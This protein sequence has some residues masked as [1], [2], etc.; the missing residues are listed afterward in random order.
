MQHPKLT[1]DNIS[2]Y[3]DSRKETKSAFEIFHVDYTDEEKDVIKNF[4]LTLPDGKTYTSYGHCGNN[5][6][7]IKTFF[8]SFGNNSD[9]DIDIVIKIINRLIHHVLL[10]YKKNYYWISIRI[11]NSNHDWDIPR[12]HRDGLYIPNGHL[13]SKFVTVVKG[14]GTFLKEDTKESKDIFDSVRKE[15]DEDKSIENYQEKEKKWRPKFD[16][17]LKDIKTLQL[18]NDDG[19]IFFVGD[20]DGAIHSEPKMDKSRMFISIVPGTKKDIDTL[21]EKKSGQCVSHQN[22]GY[23]NKL[24]KYRNKI[25]LKIEKLII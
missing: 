23:Y 14:P 5:I 7:N 18:E 22:G 20:H 16:E 13:S 10:G 24:N 4:D 1:P 25:S 2:N 11:A 15:F 3:L 8:K 9:K 12:W 19:L 6:P 17:K 21:I